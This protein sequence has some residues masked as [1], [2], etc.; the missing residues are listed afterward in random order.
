MT[1]ATKLFG[2]VT[3]TTAPEASRET[4]KQI[5]KAFGFVPNLMA[6]FANAPTLFN[7]YMAL[8]AQYAKGTLP[9]HGA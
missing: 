9:R 3:V 4:L 5:E 2:P 8:D 1:T 7:G 6:T